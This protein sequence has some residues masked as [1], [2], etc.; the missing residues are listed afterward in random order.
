MFVTERNYPLSG[1]ISSVAASGGW[2]V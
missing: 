2:V 1:L